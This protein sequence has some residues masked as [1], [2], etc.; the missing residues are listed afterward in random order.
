VKI[1]KEAGILRPGQVWQSLTLDQIREF[2]T[3]DGVLFPPRC[4][5]SKGDRLF[6]T[7]GAVVITNVDWVGDLVEGENVVSRVGAVRGIVVPLEEIFVWVGLRNSDDVGLRLDLRADVMM[8]MEGVETALGGGQLDNVPSGS[9]GFNNARLNVI[10]LRLA[11]DVPAEAGLRIRM[12]VRRTCSGTGHVS[13]TPRLWYN[14]R[15]VDFGRSR[16]A[17]SRFEAVVGQENELER[18]T[19]FLRGGGWKP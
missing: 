16:D 8:S 10:P 7:A 6:L 15:R 18:R 1:L 5:E 13:G 19:Y 14:G 2:L 3:G 12:L 9:S 4:F 11:G 17:G